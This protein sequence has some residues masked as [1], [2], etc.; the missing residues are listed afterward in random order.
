MPTHQDLFP[1]DQPRGE[2]APKFH[3]E[4]TLGVIDRVKDGRGQGQW[5]FLRG[6]PGESPEALTERIL[7]FYEDKTGPS[8]DVKIDTKDGLQAAVWMGRTVV[9]T[10]PEEGKRYPPNVDPFPDY[11]DAPA[12]PKP[13]NGPAP[14][15]VS[16]PVPDAHPWPGPTPTW[17]RQPASPASPASPSPAAPGEGFAHGSCKTASGGSVHFTVIGARF[18]VA[19][20]ARA[21]YNM[22]SQADDFDVTRAPSVLIRD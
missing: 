15:P 1:D 2:N 19:D 7:K 6:E 20:A 21:F 8:A 17:P 16:G 4:R 10:K 3:V 5:L 18:T 13:A 9:G 12:A 22:V 11:S 14:G